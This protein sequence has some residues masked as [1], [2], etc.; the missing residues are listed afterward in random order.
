MNIENIRKTLLETDGFERHIGMEFF[1]TP[2][3]DTCMARMHVDHRN[4]QPFGFLSGGATLALCETLAG[5][6]SNAL[7]PEHKCVGMNVCGNHV[8]T[9]FDGETV[10]AIAH[11]VHKG[12]KTHVW[13]VVVT[14]E[15]GKL[16][17]EVTVTNYVLD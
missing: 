13:R 12:K 5:V 3:P 16:I 7:C 11:L 17:S 10:T 4:R 14:N 15:E 8:H 2:E 1:S 9:A 6:A